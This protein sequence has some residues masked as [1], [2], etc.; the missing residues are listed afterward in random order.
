VKNLSDT[1]LREMSE[2]EKQFFLTRAVSR[3]SAEK[4]I[5]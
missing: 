2:A 5:P 3:K 4:E 1:A